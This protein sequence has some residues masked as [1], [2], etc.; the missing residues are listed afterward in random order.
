M[1]ALQYRGVVQVNNAGWCD[2]LDA[3]N[4]KGANL[5][6]H[7]D[8]DWLVDHNWHYY[9]ATF[10]ETTAKVYFDGVPVNEWEVD[11]TTDGSVIKGLFSNGADLKY[12]CLGGNQAWNWGDQ[13][14]GFMFDDIA[15]YDMEL[16]AKQIESI[17][18]NKK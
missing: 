8:T 12:I 3:Q 15:I 13:D 5:L 18:A 7:G 1:L 16:S 4:V 17:M 10:T 6:Y 11:G 14:P 2:F 9:T